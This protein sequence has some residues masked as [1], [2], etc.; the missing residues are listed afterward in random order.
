MVFGK[1][2]AKNSSHCRL[3]TRKCLIRRRAARQERLDIDS[4]IVAGGGNQRPTVMGKAAVARDTRRQ[5]RGRAWNAVFAA[6]GGAGRSV[7]SAFLS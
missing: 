1:G 2:F 6:P 3:R 5:H 4:R 7:V